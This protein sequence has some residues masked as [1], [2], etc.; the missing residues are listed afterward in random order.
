MREFGLVG[1]WPAAFLNVILPLGT[2]SI[3]LESWAMSVHIFFQEK[4][5]ADHSVARSFSHG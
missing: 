2:G 1:R 5:G 4:C 3:H